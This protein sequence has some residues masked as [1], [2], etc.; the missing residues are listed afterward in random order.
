MIFLLKTARR[1][2]PCGKALR[3]GDALAYCLLFSFVFIFQHQLVS[4]IIIAKAMHVGDSLTDE[5]IGGGF[6]EDGK[7]FFKR[8][9]C[10]FGKSLHYAT[11]LH[12]QKRRISFHHL[13]VLWILQNGGVDQ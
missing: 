11:I 6:V 12:A 7:C 1:A 10:E 8:K 9:A 2:M 3:G 13:T 5:F 4:Q